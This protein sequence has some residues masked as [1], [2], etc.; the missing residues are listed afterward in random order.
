MKRK[1]GKQQAEIRL[2]QIS[3]LLFGQT[4]FSD[5]AAES[6]LGPIRDGLGL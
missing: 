2:E 3:E 5:E 6:A 4:R 1:A